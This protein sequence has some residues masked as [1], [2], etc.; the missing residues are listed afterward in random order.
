MRPELQGLC[1]NFITNRDIIKSTLKWES[2]YLYPVGASMITNRGLRADGERLK[3]CRDIIKENTGAFSAFRSNARLAVIAAM[4]MEANPERRFEKATKLYNCLRKKFSASEYLALGAVVVSDLIEE[5]EF[6]KVV[7]SARNIYDRIRKEHPFL[8]SSEDSMYA[9]LLALSSKGE[10]EIVAEVETC[11]GIL[12][13]AFSMRNAVQSLAFVLAYDQRDA[14]EKC[15]ATVALYNELK[16]KGY[17][18]GTGYELATL[19]VLALLPQEQNAIIEEL[20]EIDSFLKEQKGYG[21]FGADRKQ[22]LMHAG[23][24]LAGEYLK[25][26]YV[27]QGTVAHSAIALM[28]A[29]QT[30]TCAAIVASTAAASAAGATT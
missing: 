18:Y 1:K 19:G 22:R 11:F 6:E 2:D 17:R 4:S 26:D 5:T 21:F 27:M 16:A 8:T 7:D 3:R 30:A 25:D 20:I 24:I 13:K 9:I 12:K 29:A 14:Q 10:E 15:Q 28:I 23:M